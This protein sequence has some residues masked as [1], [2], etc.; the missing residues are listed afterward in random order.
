MK[1]YY[2]TN[3]RVPNARAHSLQVLYTCD[4]LATEGAEVTLIV[5]R[6]PGARAEAAFASAGLPSRFR[7]RYLPALVLPFSIPFSFPLLTFTFAISVR[8]F[9]LRHRGYDFLYSRG[10][11]ALFLPRRRL[12]WESHIKPERL[13]LYLPLMRHA[14]RTVVVTDAYRRELAERYGIPAERICLAPDGVALEHFAHLPSRE[15]AREE[16]GLPLGTR[17][18][19]YSGSAPAWKGVDTLREA[20]KLLP[21]DYVVALIGKHPAGERLYTPGMVANTEVP[22]WLAAAD[23]LVSTAA[24]GSEI[25]ERYTSPLKVF[26]Y[27]ASGRPIVAA[28]TISHREVLDEAV[29]RFY[30]PGSAESLAEAI[31]AAVETET[32]DAS[33]AER[34]KNLAKRYSWRERARAIF[35]SITPTR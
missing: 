10:D 20:A 34:A 35:A 32:Q 16:L 17:L 6:Y 24:P 30:R 21:E 13:G 5:P 9:L 3:V 4:A 19:V 28:D 15:E 22:R 27:L 33:R 12:V 29:A 23:A 18:V 1:I 11:M 2:I 14:L 8:V 26:E 7:I 31:R 25:A